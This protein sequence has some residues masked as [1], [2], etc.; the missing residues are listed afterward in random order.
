[1]IRRFIFW[2]LRYE[3]SRCAIC[4]AEHA[5]GKLWYCR[6][7]GQSFDGNRYGPPQVGGVADGIRWP[8]PSPTIEKNA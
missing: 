8:Y 7:C 4:G 2:L 5:G 3:P 1:M 6:S